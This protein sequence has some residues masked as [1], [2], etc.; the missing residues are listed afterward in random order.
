[1]LI[2]FLKGNL[3]WKVSTDDISLESKIKKLTI[4]INK[5]KINEVCADIPK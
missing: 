4:A 3:P 2:Y 5:C 1:M